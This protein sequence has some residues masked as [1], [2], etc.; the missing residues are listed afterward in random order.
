MQVSGFVSDL[1]PHKQYSD[2]ARN[3]RETNDAVAAQYLQRDENN[4]KETSMQ[5]TLPRSTRDFTQTLNQPVINN[6][7][8]TANTKTEALNQSVINRFLTQPNNNQSRFFW[9]PFIGLLGGAALG[10]GS[11]AL[12]TLSES[13]GNSQIVDNYHEIH[14]DLYNTY[15]STQDDPRIGAA[16]AGK[17]NYNSASYKLQEMRDRATAYAKFGSHAASNH[18]YSDNEYDT[19]NVKYWNGYIYEKGPKVNLNYDFT[20]KDKEPNINLEDAQN[21]LHNGK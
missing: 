4:M 18:F 13:Q 11:H 2:N 8:N 12:W 10:A 5:P 3:I 6:F 14:S 9:M 17:L 7:I 20:I 16:H 1:A 21:L 19:V 15:Q